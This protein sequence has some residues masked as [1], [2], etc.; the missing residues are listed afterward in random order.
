[1]HK[2]IGKQNLIQGYFNRGESPRNL[3]STPPKVKVRG[4]HFV[5]F[6]FS[7]FPLLLSLPPSPVLFLFLFF[8]QGRELVESLRRLI[9]R[10][11][12]H[13]ELFLS[14]QM[15]F[16]VIKLSVFANSHPLKL[17]SLTESRHTGLNLS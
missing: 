2:V 15:V 17:D 8:K 11:V 5:Y 7:I 9:N 3:R 12:E 13:P 1:M 16:F 6:S 4:L 14:L 10:N